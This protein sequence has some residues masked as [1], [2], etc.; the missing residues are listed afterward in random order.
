VSLAFRRL[1]DADE[2]VVR[3]WLE[4]YLTEH[5]GWWLAARD[6]A[7]DPA[8]LV[9]ERGLVDRDWEELVTARAADFVQVAELDGRP[10]GIVR[11]ALREDRH[12]GLREGVLQWI[13]VDPA[14]RG[15]GVAGALV[16]RVTQWFDAHGV[17]GE[18]FV[19]AENA[20]AVRAY[21]RAGFRAVDVRMLRPRSAG[22]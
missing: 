4:A 2:P 16:E 20:V 19:T 8:Q 5:A 7:V 6:I 11:A 9:R 15:Q 14:A 1:V 13:A 22:G 17:S 3:G 10:A 12:L 18:L 21:E